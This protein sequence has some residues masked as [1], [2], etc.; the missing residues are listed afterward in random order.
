MSGFVDV[1]IWIIGEIL[2]THIN[3]KKT[4]FYTHKKRLVVRDLI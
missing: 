3:E 4:R 2:V 1:F